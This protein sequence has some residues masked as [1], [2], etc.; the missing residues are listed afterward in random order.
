MKRIPDGMFNMSVT[1]KTVIEKHGHRIVDLINKRFK[2]QDTAQAIFGQVCAAYCKRRNKE[3]SW[4]WAD[5]TALAWLEAK[6]KALCD[7][8]EKKRRKEI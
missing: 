6:T 5:G 3:E 2:D 7:Q 1:E 4:N 8:Y